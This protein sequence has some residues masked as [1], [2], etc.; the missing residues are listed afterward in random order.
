MEP[1][2][3]VAMDKDDIEVM[4]AHLQDGIVKIA[5]IHW[6]PNE[7]R[8]VVAVGRFD[9]EAAYGRQ[10]EWRRRL[11]ALR[12]DRVL[13]CKCRNVDPQEKDSVLNLLAVEFRETEA[14]AGVVELIFSGGG[15]VRLEVECLE[16]ELADL[17]PVWICT[18]C[19]EHAVEPLDPGIDAQ[20]R[21]SH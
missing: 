6:R 7:H 20:P 15:A 9:W 19:P 14:P 3:L 5:D 4:S 10:P 18:Q 17:G 16:A 1:L 8:F 21:A 2:K 11:T 13:S 12:F